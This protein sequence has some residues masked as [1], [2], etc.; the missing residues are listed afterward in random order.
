[1]STSPIALPIT[2]LVAVELRYR[3]LGDVL[4]VD[5]PAFASTIDTRVDSPDADV[6]V[7]WATVAGHGRVVVAMRVVH[8]RAR[9]RTRPATL[10][11]VEHLSLDE[12]F[13]R[14]ERTR[15]DSLAA[16]ARAVVTAQV[17]VPVSAMVH[18]G[19]ASSTREHRDGALAMV[20]GLL[21]VAE[22]IESASMLAPTHDAVR[23][24]RLVAA[25]RELS[26]VVRRHRGRPAPGATIAVLRLLSGDLALTT[27]ERIELR[28]RLDHSLDGHSWPQIA[29][30][31]RDLAERIAP[32]LPVPSL[33]Q[34][35]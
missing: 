31:L 28:S 29:V 3:P 17:Q 22:A 9:W 2:D 16:R 15:A 13:A 1:M 6:D 23:T 5:V 14:A 21:L 8:A 35:P 25:L 34:R 26:D 4:L 24:V 19:V 30:D 18:D 27:S 20:Q 11:L 33:L 7:R 10:P 12:L 32:W